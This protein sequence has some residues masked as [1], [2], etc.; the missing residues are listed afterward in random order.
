MSVLEPRPRAQ[1]GDE[2]FREGAFREE[3]G[4]DTE[5]PGDDRNIGNILIEAGKLTVNDVERIVALQEKDGIFFGEAAKQLKLLSEDDIQYALARQFNYPTVRPSDGTF[6]DE[7]VTAYE[8]FGKQA[9]IFRAIRGQLCYRWLSSERKVLTVVSPGDGEGR[10]YVAANLA[11]SFSQLGKS[12]LLIDADLRTPRQHE[13]FGFSRRVGLSAMLSGRIK[14]DE[15]DLLPEAVPFFTRLSVLG[16][17]AVPP[18]PSEL[19]SGERFA[20]ILRE[21]KRFFEVIIV[22][23]PAGQYTADVQA[24]AGAA[25][26]AVMVVRRDFTKIDAAVKLKASLQQANVEMA[27]SILNEF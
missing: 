17:G 2:A 6:G 21:L 19:F 22:D 12:T 20:S 5:S 15:L 14:K 4:S 23:S 27:G 25:G 10:S 26:S 11:V 8:P 1:H 9:E 3:L 7:L 18:N 24:L 13:I 16:A